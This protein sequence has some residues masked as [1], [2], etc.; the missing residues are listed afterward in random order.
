[1]I[2]PELVRRIC[3]QPPEDSDVARALLA[4]GARNWQSELAAPI[5]QAALLEKEPLELP[6]VEEATSE[7]R[8]E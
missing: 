5:L 4:M 8:S 6:E 1:M 7:Q 3:W 2:S